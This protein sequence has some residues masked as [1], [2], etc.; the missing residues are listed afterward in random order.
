MTA[1]PSGHPSGEGYFLIVHKDSLSRTNKHAMAPFPGF[2]DVYTDCPSGARVFSRL[3]IGADVQASLGHGLPIL[4]LLH[5]YRQAGLMFKHFVNEIPLHWSVLVPDLPGI[6]HTCAYIQVRKQHKA[7]RPSLETRARTPSAQWAQDILHVADALF[8]G[9]AEPLRLV[10]F[11]HDRG[12]RVA[13]RFALDH[14]ARVAGIALLDIVPTSHVWG[15]M[16]FEDG[17]KETHRTHHWI[18]LAAP[19]PLPETMIAANPEFYFKHTL[20]GWAGAGSGARGE[21]EPEWVRDAVAPYLDPQRGWDRIVAS[22]EDYRAGATHDLADDLASG[23][24]PRKAPG[25]AKPLFACPLLILSSQHLRARFDVDGIWTA[26]GVPG[27]GMV[28]ELPGRRR[29]DGPLPC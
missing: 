10:V 16:R 20:A 3:R 19:R 21:H 8:G 24:D 18:T 14:P 25:L 7:H 9:A 26:L 2:H 4:I 12:A 13:Y 1:R 11:G 5:G 6:T 27:N 29:V 23:I 15:A 28:A 22:C 17:H